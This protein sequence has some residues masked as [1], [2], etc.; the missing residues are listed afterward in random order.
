MDSFDDAQVY[1]KYVEPVEDAVN[2]QSEWL[3]EA[4]EHLAGD[5]DDF[6]WIINHS[7]MAK[8]SVDF[9]KC[10]DRSC[11]KEPQDRAFIAKLE[12]FGGFLPGLVKLREH[13]GNVTQLLQFPPTPFVQPD[14]FAPSV[15]ATR[16]DFVCK[17][18]SSYFP[19]KKILQQHFRQCSKRRKTV[20]P[21]SGCR[22]PVPKVIPGTPERRSRR[23]LPSVDYSETP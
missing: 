20:I 6:H 7:R 9:K 2:A 17:A 3:Q 12:P 21:G 4:Q 13:F 11:C 22:A 5:V 1:Y 15:V 19:V 10:Q 18:C 16:R 8:Y 14:L 23:A